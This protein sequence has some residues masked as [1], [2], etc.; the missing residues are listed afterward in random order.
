M[1]PEAQEG[2]EIPL[3]EHCMQAASALRRSLVLVNTIT[4]SDPAE[5]Q[6]RW[7]HARK[8]SKISQK[9]HQGICGNMAGR[10]G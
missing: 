5:G 1:T 7:L 6:D 9:A 4:T 8:M 10:L 2:E 3:E